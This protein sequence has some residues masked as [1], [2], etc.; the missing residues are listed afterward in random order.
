MKSKRTLGAMLLAVVAAAS[1]PFATIAAQA[2]CPDN[3]PTLLASWAALDDSG[4]PMTVADTPAES[5]AVDMGSLYCSSERNVP[6]SIPPLA[7][8]LRGRWV[9]AGV[10]T[11]GELVVGETHTPLTFTQSIDAMGK[12]GYT[13]QA[14]SFADPETLGHAG[15]VT[16]S[17]CADDG[18]KSA[19][20]A[21][22]D[23]G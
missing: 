5:P 22:T 8:V 4:R 12:V 14:V 2:H 16:V 13:S 6:R 21:T 10:P 18:C 3:P 9:A 1:I 17:I 11:S 23:V 15:S 7:N 20:F 19:T